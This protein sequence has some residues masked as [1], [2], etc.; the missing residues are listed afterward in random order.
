MNASHTASREVRLKARPEGRPTLADFDL[1]VADVPPPAQGEVLVRNRWMSVDPYMRGR[2]SARKSYLPPFELGQPLQGGAVGEVIA[3]RAAGFAPGDLVQSM[4]GW[5]EAF[6]APAA[7]LHKLPNL[8]FPPEAYLGVAGLPGLTAYV[9]VTR[10]AEVKAGETMFVSAASGAVGSVACQ[11]GRIR[12]ATVIGSAGGAEKCAFLREIG[13]DHVIDHKAEADLTA[14]LSRAA[15][16][17]IDAYFDNVGGA[18]LEAALHCAKPFARFALCGMISGYN[19]EAL[20]GPANIGLAVG[21]SLRLQGFIVSY[22]FDLMPAF[23]EEMAGWVAGGR[24][25]WRQ[26]VDEGI[27]NAPAAFLKLFSGENFGKMLVRL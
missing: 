20:P 19:G 26:S 25:T 3:S 27:E 22:F 16:E 15:P 8:P 1:A 14:A 24:V 2:M 23:I 6:T 10:I 9:G 21:R 5:R 7:D 18:H 11:I 4:L 13:C 12:G 17:G